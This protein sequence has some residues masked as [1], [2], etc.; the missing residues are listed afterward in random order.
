MEFDFHAKKPLVVNE[1]VFVFTNARVGEDKKGILEF[2][3]I[4][5]M[6]LLAASAAVPTP[7]VKSPAVRVA[8]SQPAVNPTI[9]SAV[10][11]QAPAPAKDN[12]VSVPKE[13]SLE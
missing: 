5:L 7:L 3:N 4:K 6:P 2:R 13:V 12:S 1:V 8:P 11:P 9:P 10:V